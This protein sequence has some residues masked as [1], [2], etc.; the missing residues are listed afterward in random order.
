MSVAFDVRC[1]GCLNLGPGIAS[2][3]DIYSN[4]VLRRDNQAIIISSR[5]SVQC[6]VFKE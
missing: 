2:F 6:I 4:P 5:S 3:I 1:L